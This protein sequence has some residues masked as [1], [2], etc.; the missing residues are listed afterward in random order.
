MRSGLLALAGVTA[1]AWQ[2][3][4]ASA[5]WGAPVRVSPSDG[6]MYGSPTVAAGARG[7][8]VAAWVRRGVGA[9]PGAG[10]LQLATRAA[11]DRWDRPR[12]LSGPGASLPRVALNERGDAAVA[13]VN[14][15]LILAAVRRGAAGDWRRGRIGETGAPVEQLLVSLDQRG[16]PALAWVERR[17]GGFQVRLATGGPAGTPWSVRR[18]RLSTPAPEPPALALSPG[19]G[20]LA[21]WVDDGRVW[22]AR[23]VAGA[24]ERPVELSDPD[25]GLPG[26]ALGGSGSALVSWSVRLP[27]G[28]PVLLAAGR[29]ARAPRW[30]AAEDVGIGGTPVVAM[31]EGGDAVVAWGV[32][33]PGREQA[34]EAST[35][36]AGG[37]WRASTIVA[38]RECGC[39]L[40]AVGAAVDGAGTAVVSW[41]R[42]GG[43]VGAASG[44]AALPPG[45]EDWDA[46]RV[47]A[48]GL[49]GAPIVAAA[50]TEGA[51]AIWS[52][53]GPGGPVRAVQRGPRPRS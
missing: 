37:V 6:A 18:A 4:T 31:N 19:R 28:T 44:V 21:A 48:S 50:P 42:E 9:P 40:S 49:A 38:R 16:R 5:Q 41:R 14:G 39:L 17:T 20:A 10:R 3:V 26:V 25:A 43:E 12:T 15:H 13:W 36:L 45:G 52:T 23:T 11:G 7:D 24:F 30:G 51:A 35:R 47:P 27:G 34:V 2:P 46:A 33:E 53:E 8:A 1:L 29:P 22:A 32:G